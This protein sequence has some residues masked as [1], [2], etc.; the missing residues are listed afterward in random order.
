MYTHIL[1]PTDG[2]ELSKMALQ[3]GVTLA[4]A[5]GARVTVVTVTMPFHVFTGIYS[6]S[7]MV[8]DTPEQYEKHM[9]ALA[10]QYLDV[11]KN[12]AAAAGVTCDLVHLEHEQPYQAIIDTAQNRG[13]DAIHMASHGRR[14]ISAILLGSETLKVLTHSAIPVIVCRRPPPATLG[15]LR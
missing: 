7:S 3:E 8:T 13:C 10:G 14:G 4:K 5:L 15:Y 2:S 1:I 12:I 6:I 9:A 11:A